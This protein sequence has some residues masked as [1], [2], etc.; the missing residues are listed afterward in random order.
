MCD[1]ESVYEVCKTSIFAAA[2]LP[3]LTTLIDNMGTNVMDLDTLKVN[4]ERC[5]ACICVE[6]ICICSEALESLRSETRE[7][8]LHHSLV[9]S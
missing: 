1:D 5:T 8:K 3:S 2:A 4:T 9:I 7:C 6:H